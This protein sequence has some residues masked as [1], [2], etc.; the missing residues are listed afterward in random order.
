MTR[1]S[2]F[3]WNWKR[4]ETKLKKVETKLKKVII[5]LM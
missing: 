4:V 1:V 2:S 5:V 3:I